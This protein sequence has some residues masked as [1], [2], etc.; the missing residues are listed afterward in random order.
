M[1]EEVRELPGEGVGGGVVVVELVF[2]PRFL[3]TLLQGNRPT[4]VVV[5]IVVFVARFFVVFVVHFFVV[6]VV[7]FFVVFVARPFV[8]FVARPFVP[9]GAL[10][11]VDEDD[12]AIHRQ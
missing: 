4:V 11:V 3:L 12:V 2:L 8:V 7:H 1:V 10:L 5:V 9:A 6:F